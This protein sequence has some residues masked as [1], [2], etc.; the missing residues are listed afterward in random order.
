[1]E[2]EISLNLAYSQESTTSSCSET[3]E[4]NLYILIQFL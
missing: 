4:S 3:D 2:S 1:M